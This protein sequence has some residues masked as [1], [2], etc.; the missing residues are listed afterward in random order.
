MTVIGESQVREEVKKGRRQIVY[1]QGDIITPQAREAIATFGLELVQGPLPAP[2]PRVVDPAT[3]V[4]RVLYRS[5]PRWMAPDPPVG[6]RPRRLS[7]L[8]VVGAGNVGTTVAHLAAASDMA[9]EITLVDVVAG[10]A[11]SVA[12]DVEH[13]SGVT[14]A[15]VKVSGG[16]E[17]GLLA[18][19]EVVVITAGRPRSPGMDRAGLIAIN[20]R[21]VRSVAEE[22]AAHAP[23]AVMVVVTNPLD[24]MTVEA[25]SASGFGRK[26]V[27]GM[28]GT[29]DSSRLRYLLA[30]EAG[31]SPRDVQA[32]CLGRHGPQMVPVLSR[33][34]I[35]GRPVGRVLS[36][37]QIQ[38]CVEGTI[39]GGGAVVSLRRTGSAFLAPGHAICEV[40]DALRGQRA[41]MIPV[42]VMLEGEYGMEGVVLGVPALFGKGGLIEVGE[43]G[44]SEEEHRA[45]R[46]AGEGVR[47]SLE[48]ARALSV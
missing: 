1:L 11:A 20:G 7:R 48:A 23:E 18:D 17:S 43:M 2:E 35:K 44:L 32:V 36:S 40:L 38:R 19:A 16:S 13:S 46:E 39:G 33:A 29:L 10:L 21:V 9:A 8:A 24:E 30:R 41:G 4:R 37:E 42:S 15:S 5:A 34:T 45:L 6:L 47:A 26:Q 28:A 27:L 31:V 12:L 3:A 14:G 25:L 22:V